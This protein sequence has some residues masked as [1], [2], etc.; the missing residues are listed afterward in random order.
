MVTEWFLEVLSTVLAWIIGL[1]PTVELPAWFDT[2]VGYFADAASFIADLGSVLP[3]GV[4]ALGLAWVLLCGVV[5]LLIRFGRIGL[6]L[7]TGG[8]GS[9]A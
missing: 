2:G 3:V 9:A 8:G 7:F 1:F 4:M 6:S 5:A